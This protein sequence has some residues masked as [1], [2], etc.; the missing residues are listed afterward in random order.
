MKYFV[1]L[2]GME[3]DVE[4]ELEPAVAGQSV[5][6]LEEGNFVYFFSQEQGN[7]VLKAAFPT[8]RVESIKL[9]V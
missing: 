9:G 5:M 2:S 1:A 8:H 3:S 7:R 6:I 4:L